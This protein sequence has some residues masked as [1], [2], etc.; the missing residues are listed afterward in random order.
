MKRVVPHA[1]DYTRFPSSIFIKLDKKVF[2]RILN[3][4]S[5]EFRVIFKVFRE[6]KWQSMK[7]VKDMSKYILFISETVGYDI[8]QQWQISDIKTQLFILGNLNGKR[9]Y[10]RFAVLFSV[11]PL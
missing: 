5:F 10:F 2:Q 3:N 1:V 11:F 6:E 4:I 9:Y 8:L 7:D